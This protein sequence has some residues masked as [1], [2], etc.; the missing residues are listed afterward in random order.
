MHLAKMTTQL[1][2]VAFS[3]HGEVFSRCYGTIRGRG[4][5]FSGRGE[6]FSERGGSFNGR[7]VAIIS[8][9]SRPL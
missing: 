2:D 1:Q 8:L 7:D 3:D 5:A 4:E 9:L 6:A